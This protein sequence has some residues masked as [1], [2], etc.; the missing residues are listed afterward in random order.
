[1]ELY[2]SKKINEV[3]GFSRTERA[4]LT[5]RRRT[6][7]NLRDPNFVPAGKFMDN[8]KMLQLAFLDKIIEE[9]DE[10]KHGNAIKPLVGKTSTFIQEQN[11]KIANDKIK[12]D[13]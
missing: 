1:M 3:P 9:C 11:S 12:M 6:L 5:K 10:D 2:S 7:K 4:S 8:S 13:L